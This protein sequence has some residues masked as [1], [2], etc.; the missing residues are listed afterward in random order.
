MIRTTTILT[1]ITITTLFIIITSST[2]VTTIMTT[3]TEPQAVGS[4]AGPA[5]RGDW[6][7]A[8]SRTVL[9]SRNS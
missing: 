6:R 3:V 7:V 8:E 1:I 9:Q 2:T 5:S 4:L